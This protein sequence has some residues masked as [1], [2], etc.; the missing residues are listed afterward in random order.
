MTSLKILSKQQIHVFV[1]L[2][3]GYSL[4]SILR[5]PLALCWVPL[6]EEMELSNSN[7]GL[8]ISNYTL[9]FGFSKLIGGVLSDRIPSNILLPASLTVSTVVNLCIATLRKEYV[10]YLGVLWMLNGLSQGLAW[11]CI[12]KIIID[13]FPVE[14]MGTLWSILTSVSVIV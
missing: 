6:R 4:F 10:Y 5:K 11:P 3:L 12:A 13:C 1:S 14:V 2:F 8:I 9:I 7:Y